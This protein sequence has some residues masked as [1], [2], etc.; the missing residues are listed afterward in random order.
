MSKKSNRTVTVVGIGIVVL[1]LAFVLAAVFAP[2]IAGKKALRQVRRA[3]E[4]GENFQSVTILNP[5]AE[6]EFLPTEAEARLT[7]PQVIDAL[8]AE[9]LGYMD[10][11]KYGGVE[12]ASNGNWDIRVRFAGEA[13]IDVYLTEEYFYLSQNGR[14]FIFTPTDADGYTLWR[15][16][17]LETMFRAQ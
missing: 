12:D 6:S 16:V 17:W 14:R 10:G 9:L 3:L 5:R 2:H 7:D 11:A 1:A 13:L 8:R 4:Q 15:N